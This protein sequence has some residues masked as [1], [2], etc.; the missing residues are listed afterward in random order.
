MLGKMPALAPELDDR[1]RVNCAACHVGNN[2]TDGGFH[3]LGLDREP[4]PG[5]ETGRF[6]TAPLGEKSRYL[7]GAHKTPTLRSLLR[8]GPYY[9]DG[10]AEELDKVVG[11]H[12]RVVASDSYFSEFT[13]FLCG[14]FSRIMGCYGPPMPP[15]LKELLLGRF[16]R[17]VSLALT[18]ADKVRFLRTYLQ[19]G[20]RGR[21]SWKR[22]WHEVEKATLAKVARNARNG[23]PLA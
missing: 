6:V 18:R 15:P 4:V 8:T 23:R 3:N 13:Y 11:K 21:G 7:I 2:F 12:F 9:H 19:W 1:H 10:S 5:Q 14:I 22:W 16:L 17:P 20:L